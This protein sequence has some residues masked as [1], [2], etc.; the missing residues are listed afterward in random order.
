MNLPRF[1][2]IPI[3]F[4]L[5]F[6]WVFSGWPPVEIK[7]AYAA[8]T[9]S[10]TALANATQN[11]NGR[12]LFIDTNDNL[13][14]AFVN[15]SNVI[16]VAYCN[17]GGCGSWTTDTGSIGTAVSNLSAVLDKT[18]NLILLAY[19]ATVANKEAI[20]YA[21][22]TI[23]YSGAN[24]SDI[25]FAGNVQLIASVTN[26]N[27]E[28][29]GIVLTHNAKPGVVFSK[30]TGGGVNASGVQYIR[31]IGTC[32]G[33]ASSNWGGVGATSGDG[34]IDTLY[35]SATN[36]LNFLATI[37]QMPG[38]GTAAK[39]LYVFFS[40]SGGDALTYVAA[41]CVSS[42]SG[43]PPTWTW[44]SLVT[45]DANNVSSTRYTD[46][47]SLATSTNSQVFVVWGSAAATFCS[48]SSAFCLTSWFIDKDGG[49]SASAKRISDS[50]TEGS[51]NTQ[52]TMTLYTGSTPDY[53]TLFT[54]NSSGNITRQIIEAP[55]ATATDWTSGTSWDAGS[56]VDSGTGNT[57]PSAKTDDAGSQWD[58]IF[59]SAANTLSYLSG[60]IA[61]PNAPT[62]DS[63]ANGAT[64][65]SVTPTFLMTATDPASDNINYKVTIYSESSCTTVVQTHNEADAWSLRLSGTN[66]WFGVGSDSDGSNLIAGQSAGRLYTSSNYGASWTE[67]QPAG[68][69]NREWRAIDSDNDG[70]NLIAGGG[71]SGATAGRL[72]RSADS[73]ANWEEEQ[74]DGNA[75]RYWRGAGSDADGSVLIA[76]I[77]DSATTGNLWYSTNFGANWNSATGVG[78]PNGWRHSAADADGSVILAAEDTTL[79]SSI[80]SGANWVNELTGSFWGAALDDDGTFMIASINGGALQISS[81]TGSTWYPADIQ[82]YTTKTWQGVDADSDGSFLIAGES[83]RLWTSWDSGKTW[84]ERRP[85]GDANQNWWG[86]ATDADGTN[87]IAGIN[88]GAL[89]TYENTWAGTN[90]VCTAEPRQCYTS[91]TQGSYTLN[92]DDA[93]TA[94]TQYWW[95]ASARD[96]DDFGSYTD[97]TTCNSFTTAG[98]APPAVETNLT[99]IAYRWFA[100]NNSTDVGGAGGYNTPIIAPKEGTPIRL[101]L[102]FDVGGDNDLTS[103]TSRLQV[104]EKP[105]GGCSAASFSDVGGTTVFTWADNSTP[106]DGAALTANSQDPRYAATSTNH[107]VINQTYNESNDFTSSQ[108]TVDSGA[109]M[110]FDLSLSV[111]T[112]SIDTVAKG[113]KTFCLQAV[114]AGGGSFAQEGGGG[115]TVYPEISIEKPEILRLR[116]T[117]RL[118]NVRLR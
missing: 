44:Q 54:K 87:L 57:W 78:S 64:G 112:T 66:S 26:I 67:R 4:L 105:A 107:V 106:S 32:T 8:T 21:E 84:Y 35:N 12:K 56:A 70:T 101:R 34:S 40:E 29:P 47:G 82:D 75:D 116:G 88:G 18:N 41:N 7:K 80:D 48:G 6:V 43:S 31:C 110:L 5:I 10:T 68:V 118:R 25:T 102:L 111:S 117:I 20:M 83:T 94:A 113:G 17:V 11:S 9:V 19:Q 74:P 58:I 65:V 90:A 76:G 14:A 92:A 89:Y 28:R 13:L 37:E 1:L 98:G 22:A 93:L 69:V 30:R 36:A 96:P 95:K 24:I 51:V 97:S 16:K 72:W 50:T 86:V 73:G 77:Y 109:G 49:I 79:W 108:G 62:Q 63:P 46:V 33:A 85:A 100:N 114:Q 52:P 59:M 55:G 38:S 3:V 115:Y 23:V 45:K 71:S 99:Q 61:P 104:G 2:R 103:T 39:R 60:L 91:G 53:L 27:N 15:S 42:C 81:S